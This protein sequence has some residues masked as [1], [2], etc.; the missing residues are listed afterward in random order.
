[1]PAYCGRVAGQVFVNRVQRRII[2]ANKLLMTIRFMKEMS[3]LMKA[4]QVT[5]DDE[6]HR[7]SKTLAYQHGVT[8]AEFIRR[9][10]EN[11]VERFEA[12]RVNQSPDWRPQ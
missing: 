11:Q 1:M 12:A 8:L 4:I 3:F 7:R 5:L 2:K 10:I 9:A 6:L